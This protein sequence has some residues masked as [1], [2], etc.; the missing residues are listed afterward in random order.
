VA[1]DLFARWGLLSMG[2]ELAGGKRYLHLVG[3]RTWYDERP[4]LSPP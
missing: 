3:A 2:V 4:A 1:G